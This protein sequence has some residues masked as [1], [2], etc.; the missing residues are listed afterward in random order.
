[1]N[2]ILLDTHVAIWSANGTVPK[3]A[4]RTIEEAVSRGELLLSP[5]SAWEIGMLVRK[6]RLDLHMPVGDFVRALFS[7]RGIV[8]A[9]LTPSIAAAATHLPGS[10]HGDPADRILVA[11][12]AT[13][14]A[15]LVT[16]D[17][18]LHDYARRTRHIRCIPC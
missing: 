17:R 4:A 7:Q 2:P 18:K 1:M 13:L 9:L 6:Q 14:G 5:I 10:L 16:R 12:A 3:Q 8:T 15:Q 11:T